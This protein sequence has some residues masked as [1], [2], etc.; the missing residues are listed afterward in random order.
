[1]DRDLMFSQRNNPYCDLL[2]FVQ[3][4]KINWIATIIFHAILLN[5]H[6]NQFIQIL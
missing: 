5:L 2:Q 1:M 3:S 4:Y 6:N